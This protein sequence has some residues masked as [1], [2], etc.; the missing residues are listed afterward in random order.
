VN[1]S[2]PFVVGID[3]GTS[4]TV[5]ASARA[6]ESPS[7]FS[8]LQRVEVGEREPRVLF[9]SC[10]YAY[11][12]GEIVP[13]VAL[14]EDDRFTFGAFAK[15]RSVEVPNRAIVSAKSW[16]CH[17]RVDRLAP[18]LPWG[19]TDA[20][21]LSPVDVAERILRHVRVC[22]DNAHPHAPLA[23]QHVVLTVPASFDDAAR[24]L[25]I[26]AAT[27]AGLAVRLLE[28]PQAAY[29]AWHRGPHGHDREDVVLVVDVGGGTTDLSLLKRAE[30]GA[31]KRIAVGPHLLLGG[32]NMDLALAHTLE[33]RLIGDGRDKLSP[34]AF[35]ELTLRAREA[36]EIL[37]ASDNDKQEVTVAV[38]HRGSA[39]FQRSQSA[40][41]SR[42]DVGRII[43]EGFFPTT[44]LDRRALRS[45]LVAFG[46]PYERNVAITR[47]V[48]A[49]LSRHLPDEH[50]SAVLFNGGVFRAP[51]LRERLLSALAERAGHEV[52]CLDGDAPD[53]AVAIGA[54]RFGL[55]ERGE[56]SVFGGGAS[57]AYFLGL[58]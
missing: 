39:L 49:F 41:L 25:T 31:M 33:P 54:V 4:H 56:G 45:G 26:I 43:L 8:I 47:H 3:L 38:A 42:E 55:A 36:K 17:S 5:V 14:G 22:W 57:R 51:L 34:I 27:R 32:D 2:A 37:L 18:I 53:T 15:R 44:D 30:D 52:R 13:E 16:L 7:L 35:A 24:E 6:G 40:K 1:T 50:V 10:A 46:L 20:S 11:L 48:A 29:Y 19:E 23:A 21:K 12:D 58:A 9:P 28:E